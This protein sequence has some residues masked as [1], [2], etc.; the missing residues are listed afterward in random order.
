MQEFEL[1][2]LDFI[3]NNVKNGFF[4]VVMP[5]VTACGNLG[6]FWVAVALVI[7]TKAKYRK[8]SITMLIGLIAGVL[9]GNLIIKKNK[10]IFIAH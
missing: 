10:K 8:C 5:M 2:I 3:R 4:D 6:I 9:I 7:S 1:E